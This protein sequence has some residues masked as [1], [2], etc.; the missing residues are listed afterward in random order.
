MA[1]KDRQRAVRSA[2]I[3]T[4]QRIYNN[5]HLKIVKK[6]KEKKW[7]CTIAMQHAGSRRNEFP[8]FCCR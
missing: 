8:Y 1:L 7:G 3:A 6:K 5:K 2:A 4:E